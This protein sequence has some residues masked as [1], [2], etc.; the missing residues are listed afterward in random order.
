MNGYDFRDNE[1]AVKNDTYGTVSTNFT[2]HTINLK[3]KKLF[4][5][6]VASELP[7]N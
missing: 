3:C 4:T 5:N 6:L 7:L 1:T 2:I